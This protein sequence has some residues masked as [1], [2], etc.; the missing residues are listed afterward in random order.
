MSLPANL[1]QS[2][3][4]LKG[5]D[6]EAFEKVHSSGEQVTSIRLNPEKKTAT[7]Y[8]D[9]EQVPWCPDG[10]YLR[11]RPS[12][13]LDPL[14]HAG[15]YYVQEASSMFLWH[16]LQETF[17]NDRHKK[18]LDLCAAPGGKSTLLASFFTEGL[19]VANEVI[20]QRASVLV[21]NV[22]KWGYGHVV[23]TNN[24]PSHFRSLPGYFDLI[25]VDAPCS[26]SGMFRKD[27]DAIAEWS[28]ESVEL[29]KQRQQRI[30]VDVLDSLQEN[31]ILIYSTCSYSKDENELIADWLV[32][33]MEMESIQI[34]IPAIW[35]IVETNSDIH[36]AFGY[37]FYPNFIKGEGLYLAAFR[38]K[39]AVTE[40]GIKE[41]KLKLA[42]RTE[43][44]ISQ[45]FMPLP[46]VWQYFKQSDTIRV[47][48]KTYFSDLEKIAANLYIKKAGIAIGAIKGKDVIPDHELAV[49]ILPKNA[50]INFE[51]SLDEALNY[52]RRKDLQ[53]AQAAKGWSLF[54]YSG[55]SLGWAKVLPNRV[56]NYYPAEWRI[57]KE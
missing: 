27:K 34:N 43:I 30:L 7:N 37:R 21:E 9:F 50:F 51:L 22:T 44:Q 3:S 12:F 56:N 13:T 16:A 32:E 31:G 18:V 4:K 11:A 41:S 1:L 47:I 28:L 55:L 40:K 6:R 54:N 45:E 17:G 25:M 33:E 29:C 42:S 5:F 46:D 57:L 10:L 52:L 53:L 14:F 2:L 15:A 36:N 20:K 49:S 8:T 48:S 24:D 38:K 35:G 39:R 23:V 26:G 19:V